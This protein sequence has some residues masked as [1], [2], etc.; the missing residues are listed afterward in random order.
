MVFLLMNLGIW[1]ELDG[2]DGG[3]HWGPFANPDG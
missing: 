3:L 1:L 2:L